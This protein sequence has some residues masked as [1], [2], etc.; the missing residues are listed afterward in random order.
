MEYRYQILTGCCPNP[1]IITTEA[2]SE[3]E[4]LVFAVYRSF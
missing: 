1:I 3:I 4:Y 2:L